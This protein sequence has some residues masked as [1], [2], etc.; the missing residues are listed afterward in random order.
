MAIK[1]NYFDNFK[2]IKCCICG[3]Y[4]VRVGAFTMCPNCLREEFSD[5]VMRTQEIEA[6]SKDR[7]V[8]SKWLSEY[9]K[10]E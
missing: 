7:Q 8:Y 5:T 3:P 2:C 9:L 10:G 4:M 1:I 6:N